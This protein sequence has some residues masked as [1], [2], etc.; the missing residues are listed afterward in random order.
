MIDF[1]CFCIAF[2][3]RT[4][5]HFAVLAAMAAGIGNGNANRVVKPALCAKTWSAY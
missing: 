3:R 1:V 5:V 4:F 2:K